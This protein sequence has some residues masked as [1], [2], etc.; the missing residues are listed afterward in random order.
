MEL[1]IIE[2][3]EEVPA[4]LQLLFELDQGRLLDIRISIVFLVLLGLVTHGLFESLCDADIVN[5]Q[6][7]GFA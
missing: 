1:G 4:Y 5:H 2:S 6:S 3:V 7:T